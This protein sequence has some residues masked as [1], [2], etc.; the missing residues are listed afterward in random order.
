MG[1]K[2]KNVELSEIATIEGR[3]LLIHRKGIYKKN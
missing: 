1:R 3:Y 2:K